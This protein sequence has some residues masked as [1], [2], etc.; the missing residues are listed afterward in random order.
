SGSSQTVT[1]TANSGYTFTN[2]TVN[3]SVVSSSS[4]YTFTVNG[5]ETLVANF[6]ANPVNYTIAVSALPS[7]GGTV[8]GAGTFASGSSQT[9]TAT[10]NSG[11]TFTN[12][13]VN[14]SV[15]SSSSS[16]T[17]TVNGNQTLVAN[18]TANPVNYTIAVSASPIAGGTVSG[19][20]TF[21]SGSSRTVTATA[22]SD[23][24]F[25]NWTVN[26]SVVSSSSSYTFTVSGNGTLVA[27]F[28]ANPVNY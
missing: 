27:N 5:N 14:G 16:Y 18:F 1:A 17:F 21:A 13:T 22:N 11:Y 26:G 3:G 7:A 25:T 15:V 9:V 8:S 12:W 19:A 2:W 4:S 20:G 28:T 6:T 24:T 10:A 23:Y